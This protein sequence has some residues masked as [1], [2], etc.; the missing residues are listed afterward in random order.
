MALSDSSFARSSALSVSTSNYLSPATD[1]LLVT[2]NW[3][4][5]VRLAS[6]P[7]TDLAVT[8]A[9]AAGTILYWNVVQLRAT[10]AGEVVGLYYS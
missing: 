10:T 3:T 1:A 5:T 8:T 6:S 9:I 7:S 4:G 2:D